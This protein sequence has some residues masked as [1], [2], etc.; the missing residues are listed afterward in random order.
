MRGFYITDDGIRLHAKLDMPAGYEEGDKCPLVIIIHGL[1]GHMEERHIKGLAAMMNEE[2]FST[3]RAE[4]Y[5]HGASEGDF[6]S[7]NLFKWLNNAMTVTDYARSLPFVTDLYI[8]GHSQG[9]LTTI[10]AAGMM[11]EYFKAVIPLSPAVVLTDGARKGMNFGL[12]FAE[13]EIPDEVYVNATQK[14]KGNYLRAARLID[15]DYAISLYHGPVLIVHGSEDEAV[16]L[17]YAEET[18][19]KYDNAQLVI[20]EGDDHCFDYHLDEMLDAVREFLA[21][22]K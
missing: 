19:A 4:M 17:S 9:G 16:P 1:T 12:D 7:H 10:L 13:G 18:A 11:P 21:E 22:N 6:S 3:L 14:V 8:S 5:G 20:I 15:T 2:G